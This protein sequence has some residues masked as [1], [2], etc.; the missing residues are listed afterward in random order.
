MGREDKTGGKT[1]RTTRKYSVQYQNLQKVQY[2]QRCC[3]N[4]ISWKNFHYQS[5]KPRSMKNNTGDFSKKFRIYIE[6]AK[7]LLY[8]PP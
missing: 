4:R 2:R 8:N 6:I 1:E 7:Y 3:K 5:R